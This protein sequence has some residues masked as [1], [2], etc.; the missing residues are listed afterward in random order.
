MNIVIL[1]V[2]LLT[3]VLILTRLPP[4]RFVVAGLFGLTVYSSPYFFGKKLYFFYEASLLRFLGDIEFE[5][6]ISLLLV[7]LTVFFTLYFFSFRYRTFEVQI[8]ASET[9]SIKRFSEA[10]LI[11]AILGFLYLAATSGLLFFLESREHQENSIVTL[12]WK[13]TVPLGLISALLIKDRVKFSFFLFFLA[14]LFLRGDRTIFSISFLTIFV[15]IFYN[16]RTFASILNPGFIAVVL[17]A[18]FTIVFG[19]P[20]YLFAKSGD[21]NIL[22]DAIQLNAAMH[23]VYNFEPMI[24]ANHLDFAILNDFSIGFGEF[25]V[26]VF[27]NLLIFPSQFGINTNV[28]NS[29][30]SEAL[31]FR[32][33]YGIAG[34]YWA[35]AWSVGGQFMVVVYAL[36]YAYSLVL[37]DRW[38]SRSQGPMRVVV[39]CIGGLVAV[40]IY[41][42]G[43]DNFL[44][45][46]RQILI[47]SFGAFLLSKILAHFSRRKVK[48]V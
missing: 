46:I 1:F 45:F 15:V 14:V 34:N 43:L 10:L 28:Y 32:L 42:N 21:F 26:G 17:I 37:C 12:L 22:M 4:F 19:K 20:I 30:L 11:L 13:W 36:I 38:Y 5:A 31:P 18:V 27:G 23:V 3:W 35:H 6:E 25:F 24:V 7:W 9:N 44:S 41:R 16:R 40:Y 2:A 8:G 29:L 48:A 39:A 33:T 47:V